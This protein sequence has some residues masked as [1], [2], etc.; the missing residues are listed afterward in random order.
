[1]KKNEATKNEMPATILK[2][3]LVS[4][5]AKAHAFEKAWRQWNESGDDN[6]YEI[7]GDLA[8]EFVNEWELIA[9]DLAPLF[10]RKTFVEFAKKIGADYAM[11]ASYCHDWVKKANEMNA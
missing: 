7:V 11:L 6:D 9:D 2:E 10:N 1:M 3:A 5:W 8:N 4:V